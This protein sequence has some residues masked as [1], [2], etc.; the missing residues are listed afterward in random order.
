ML[1]WAAMKGPRAE[2]SCRL[3]GLRDTLDQTKE[4]RLWMADPLHSSW[5]T[6]RKLREQHLGHRAARRNHRHDRLF[7]RDHDVDQHRAG[8]R[9]RL[10][11]RPGE[12]PRLLDSEALG[13]VSVGEL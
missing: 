1:A 9:E 6:R 8:R 7:L 3:E 12:V 13:A 5:E 11:H 4:G 2:G 10:L